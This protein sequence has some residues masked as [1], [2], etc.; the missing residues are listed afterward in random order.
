MPKDILQVGPLFWGCISANGEQELVQI[1]DPERRVLCAMG[2]Y[3]LDR[4]P[5][6]VGKRR[7]ATGLKQLDIQI[8]L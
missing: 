8:A 2:S 4:Y 6:V 3:V 1:V 5:T 7:S